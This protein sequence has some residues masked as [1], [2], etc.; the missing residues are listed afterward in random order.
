MA[1]RP[2]PND[3]FPAEALRWWLRELPRCNS[4]PAPGLPCCQ[5]SSG[6]VHIC[7][8]SKGSGPSGLPAAHLAKHTRML[9]CLAETSS[10]RWQSPAAE[11][12]LPKPCRTSSVPVYG[13]VYKYTC[14]GSVFS[15]RQRALPGT[16]GGVRLPMLPVFHGEAKRQIRLRV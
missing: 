5:Q 15:T 7:A 16:K 9:E 14:S 12:P 3:L 13:Y 8:P 1:A 4:W 2:Q 11:P 6:V 10:S